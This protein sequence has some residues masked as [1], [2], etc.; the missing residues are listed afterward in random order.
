MLTLHTSGPPAWSSTER[1]HGFIPIIKVLYV[2]GIMQFVYTNNKT[3]R[4][5]SVCPKKGINPTNPYNPI[6]GMGLGPHQSYGIFGR[7]LDFKLTELSQIVRSASLSNQSV[8]Y[9]YV[10][11]WK[12]WCLKYGKHMVNQT[13]WLIPLPFWLV[14][15]QQSNWIYICHIV[16]SPQKR[17]L[18]WKAKI[19]IKKKPL[20]PNKVPWPPK[21]ESSDIIGPEK[22]TWKNTL[23][24]LKKIGIFF[25]MISPYIPWETSDPRPHCAFSA[26]GSQAELH[27]DQGNS[28]V[29]S[30]P[31]LKR[32]RKTTNK[33]QILFSNISNAQYTFCLH[34]GSFFRPSYVLTTCTTAKCRFEESCLSGIRSQ[35]LLVPTVMYYHFFGS[36]DLKL[37]L[38]LPLL[39]GGKA[40]QTMTMTIRQPPTV[41]SIKMGPFPQLYKQTEVS[42][43]GIRRILL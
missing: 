2:T 39:V 9:I 1:S 23:P 16:S 11:Y 5:W 31:H 10:H 22:L 42:T 25:G 18:G 30:L 13:S 34:S 28:E 40:S 3:L 8:W 32:G 43:W 7:G 12:Q 4:I 14:A 26:K 36:R 24:A 15:L 35:R 20:L 21:L 33:K 38:P 27:K 29:P 17:H 41:R 6:L 19:N 37:N